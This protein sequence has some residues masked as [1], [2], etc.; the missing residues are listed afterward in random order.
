MENDPDTL[1]WLQD[2]ARSDER[3]DVRQACVKELGER[4][5]ERPRHA[6]TWLQDLTRSD[7]VDAPGVCEAEPAKGWKSDP[8][9][10][11]RSKTGL[12]TKVETWRQACAAER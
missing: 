11:C 9:R 6:A 12:A 8:T 10:C 1:P 4:M 7:E 2:R 5:E 3:G